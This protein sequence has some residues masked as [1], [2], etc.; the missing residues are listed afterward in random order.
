MLALGAVAAL[1]WQPLPLATN[2]HHLH[3]RRALRLAHAQPVME[4]E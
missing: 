2:P 4:V 3:S 1:A